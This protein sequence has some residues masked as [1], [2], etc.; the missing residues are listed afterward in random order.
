MT[1]EDLARYFRERSPWMNRPHSPDGFKVGDPARPLTKVAVSWKPNWEALRRAV[2]LG[3]EMFIGHESIFVDATVGSE[4]DP[5]QYHEL[6]RDKAQWIRE[7]GLCIYRCHDTIDYWPEIGIRDAWAKGLGF[8]Q[9]EVPDPL[10]PYALCHLPPTPLHALA[11]QIVRKIAPLGQ[12]GV[13]V[14][15]DPERLIHTIVTGTGAI[16]RPF[17][18]H[19]YQPDCYLITE[20]YF[21]VVREGEW[22]REID[23][24]MIMVNHGV[25]EEWGMQAYCAH[26]QATFPAIE[27]VFIPH[28]CLY[29][30]QV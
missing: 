16:T 14:M 26:L 24:A 25:S 1:P 2:E 21:R 17:E 28:P 18:M 29:R 4:F 19:R 6:E 15:G 30:I 8:S 27:F 7:S 11:N 13:M 23:A 20:D 10:G 12:N 3:C 5:P 22:L 9:R